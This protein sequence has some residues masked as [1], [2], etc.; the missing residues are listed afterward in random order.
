MS[1]DSAGDYELS[2]QA[3]ITFE[4]ARDYL[5][6]EED[7]LPD[8]GTLGPIIDG[9]SRQI[10]E[11]THREYR[12]DAEAA[13]ARA[14]S[15]YGWGM[16]WI[17][18]CR[19]VE[20]VEITETPSDDDAWTLVD[21][22]DWWTTPFDSEIKERVHFRPDTIERSAIAVQVTATWGHIVVPENV[23]LACHMWLQNIHKRDVA[24]FSEEIART[25]AILRMPQDVRD[26]LDDEK[27]TPPAYVAVK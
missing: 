23:T 17:D 22:D 14:F 10:I 18:D 13:V 6:S 24:F 16:V 25:S 7:E 9:I 5:Q 3:L 20:E 12:P 8:T 11:H 27:R 21:P 26:I 1:V 4:E 19:D 2:A 15:Y